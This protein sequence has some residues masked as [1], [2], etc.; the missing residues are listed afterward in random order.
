MVRSDRGG[1]FLVAAFRDMCEQASIKRQFTA[2][3]SPQ[4]NVVVERRN[5]TVMEMARSLQKC[6]SVQGSF[7]VEVVRHSVYLLN[8]LP[9]KATGS[10]TPFEGWCGRKPQL[11]HLKVFGCRANVRPTMPHLKKLFDRSEPMVY[12]GVEEGSKSHRLYDP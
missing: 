5:R 6:M 2:P 1:E 3:Y 7:W 9:T 11:G 8:R 12:F 4:Q 10:R